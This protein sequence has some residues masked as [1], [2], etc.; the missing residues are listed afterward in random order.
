[1]KLALGLG[2]NARAENLEGMG[3][4][5]IT[6][7]D[8]LELWLKFDEGQGAITDG[9]QWNDSSGNERHASQTADAQEGS[10]FSGGAFVTD[11]G[12]QDNLDF[13]STFSDAG[14][15]HVFMVLDLSEESNET[16]L[17]SVDNSSFMRFAQ[18]GTAEDF[19]MKNGGTTLNMTLSSGFGLTKAIAEVSRD[20]SN[21]VR[22]GKNGTGLSS[23]TGAGTFSF[24][25][26]GSSSNGLT[27][28][29]I[30]EVVIFNKILSGTTL[31]NVRNDIADRNGITI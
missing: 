2:I 26:I 21:L 12:S 14:D 30:F 6:D 24:E 19:R 3:G 15:Y 8:G 20:G 16:F 10:G 17:S 23:G 11:A 27:S 28:A 5:A 31:S 4:F 25:Q 22:V 29:S 18:G 9:I 13:A 7:V 1:M